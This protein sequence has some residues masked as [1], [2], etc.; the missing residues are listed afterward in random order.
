[1]SSGCRLFYFKL[2]FKVKQNIDVKVKNKTANKERITNTML[3]RM[4]NLCKFS[5]CGTFFRHTQNTR[6]SP[7]GTKNYNFL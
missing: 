7:N 5:L 2:T 6:L 4:M 1:M 3:E